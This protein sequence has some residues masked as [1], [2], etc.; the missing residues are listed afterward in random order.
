MSIS[1]CALGVL[2]MTCW[3]LAF[4]CNVISK[5][6]CFFMPF[7]VIFDGPRTLFVHNENVLHNGYSSC[8]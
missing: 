8:I 3:L 1:S 7:E 6:C 4:L 5:A 2:L